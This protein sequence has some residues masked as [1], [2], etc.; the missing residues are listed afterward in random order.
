MGACCA[1]MPEV[2]T[3]GTSFSRLAI[4]YVEE[5]YHIQEHY[6]VAETSKSAIMYYGS[7]QA[8]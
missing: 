3:V 6:H 7:R 4:E 8:Y 5:A 2:R 1:W